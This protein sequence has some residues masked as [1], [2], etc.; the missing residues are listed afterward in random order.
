MFGALDQR[1]GCCGSVYALPEDAHFY[2][3]AACI[4][5]VLEQEC[6]EQ[7]RRFFEKKRE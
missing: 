1:Q 6:A 5:G 2:H 3:R 4:G 7:L